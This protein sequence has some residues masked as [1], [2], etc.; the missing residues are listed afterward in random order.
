M[1]KGLLTLLLISGVAQAKNLGTWGEM[2]PIAE[3]N[4]LTT[5]QTRLKA[6]EASG[7]MAREQ[8]AFKQR[9][10]ENTLRPRPVEGLTLAQENTTHYIDPS[11]TV[12]EDLKDHQ[13]RVFAH[14]GQVINPLDT[15]PFTD[16]LYFIDADNPQQLAWMKAQKPGTL[17]YRVILVN[18]DVREA[19]NALNTRIYFDQ[20]GS[21]CRKFKLKAIPARV[22]L[23]EDRRRLRVDTFAL[24]APEVKP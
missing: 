7:E 13:G 5:I 4:M 8:E 6:M 9:V 17:T 10:I 2:Y 12:S 11:L 3:Q 15:V 22:T 14:K 16:T 19:T 24:D 21:L 18:G 20:D 1:K 23:A